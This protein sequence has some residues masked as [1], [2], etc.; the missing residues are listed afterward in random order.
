MNA[1]LIDA[2]VDVLPSGI[3]VVTACMPRVESVAVGIWVGVGSR[4]ETLALSGISH[5]IEHL[6]FKGTKRLSAGDVSRIVE[7]CG[8]CINAFTQEEMTCYYA[9]M[10]FN[11][12][13]KVLGVLCDLIL[14]P[15][16]AQADVEKERNV[17]IEEIM[18]YR[19]HPDQMVEEMLNGILWKNHKLGKPIAG[20]PGSVSRISRE[21]IV[22][23][24]H[25]N[26]VGFNTA[27]VFAGK[28]RRDQAVERVRNLMAGYASS[29][30][31]RMKPVT[32]G[33]RQDMFMIK[34][35]DIEQMQ[36][37]AGF[38]I[39]GLRDKRR[40]ALKLLNVI[41]GENMSSRLFQIIREKHGLAYSVQSGSQLFSDTGSLVVSAGLDR[42]RWVKAF[43][44]IINEI[45]RM[46][47]DAVKKSELSRAVEYVVGN[48]RL[49][50]ESPSGQ[51]MWIGSNMMNYGSPVP[52]EEVMDAVRSVSRDDIQKLAGQ[53]LN[54]QN[55]SIALLSPGIDERDEDRLR[56]VMDLL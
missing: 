32:A 31:P 9:R 1:M 43:G 41:L 14:R 11:H 48:I 49:G 26:Y 50:V 10:A 17:I 4:H 5:F 39:F 55:A 2:N 28:I 19:D 21:D 53:I 6:L 29:A 47:Q 13:W 40:F 22:G 15:R 38:R 46:K 20:D 18:M 25:R 52:P 44:L 42:E 36:M 8:G 35:K 33:V 24:K 7:G 16:F 3:R 30:P 23:F 56:S 12:V 37:A 27:V 51:M 45:R 54:R 34:K